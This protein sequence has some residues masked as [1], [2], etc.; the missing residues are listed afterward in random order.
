MTELHESAAR[1][2]LS[3]ASDGRVT[4]PA[5][6]RHE[7]GI[8]PGSSLVCYVEHG[9]VV[10][11]DRRH[12]LARIQDEVLAAEQAAGHAGSVVD[13]LI[14]ERRAEAAREDAEDLP[15]SGA[16]A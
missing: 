10:L 2:D 4:I 9:R 11:E 14:A 1:A 3:V 8:E 13:E 15:D 16:T 5:Q 7:A 12:L 6:V